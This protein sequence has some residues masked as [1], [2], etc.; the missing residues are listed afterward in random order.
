[1]SRLQQLPLARDIIGS[2]LCDNAVSDLGDAIRGQ[3]QDGRSCTGQTDSKQTGLTGRGHE[4]EN[5]G[6]AWDQ[7]L[8]IRLVH[9]ILHGEEDHIRIRWGASQGRGEECRA[10]E[11][12]DLAGD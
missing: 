8:A 10:L 1:M 11:I 5:L 9:L 7:R 12:E 3:C 4:L 6:Q 2:E